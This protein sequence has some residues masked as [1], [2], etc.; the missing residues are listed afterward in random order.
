MIPMI[1]TEQCQVFSHVHH[2][3]VITDPEN[4][5]HPIQSEINAF[6]A[7]G[8]KEITRVTQSSSLLPA[9]NTGATE[10]FETMTLIVIYY[11]TS[12]SSSKVS[13]HSFDDEKE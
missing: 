7:S 6:L 11:T 1:K 10:Q 13:P 12:L 3:H 9:K 5:E 2:R 8:D 4:Y